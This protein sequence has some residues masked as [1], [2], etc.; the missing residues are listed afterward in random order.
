MRGEFDK[1]PTEVIN[2]AINAC[3]WT[4][5]NPI[6]QRRAIEISF[7]IFQQAREAESVD[8]VTFGLM[9]KTCMRLASDDETRFKLVAVRVV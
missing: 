1:I 8:A 6:V 2:A 5:G 4:S 3:A 9:I 7:G